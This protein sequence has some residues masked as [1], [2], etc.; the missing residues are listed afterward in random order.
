M[1]K[2]RMIFFAALLLFVAFSV[3]WFFTA[4][5]RYTERSLFFLE[6]VS[7]EVVME[8]RLIAEKHDTEKNIELLVKDV[9]LGSSLLVRD[10]IFPADTN[11]NHLL[12]RN[13]TV[14]ADLS[15]DAVFAEP[16]MGLAFSESLDILRRTI[17]F[18]FPGIESVTI[19]VNGLQPE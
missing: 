12:L 16:G 1:K 18:N 3:V 13:G 7:R 2:R 15:M 10:G 14:Y 19:T 8:H 17:L 4:E 9:L 11:L 5:N 6:P